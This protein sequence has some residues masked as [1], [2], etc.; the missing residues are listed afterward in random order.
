MVE[1]YASPSL[2]L[3]PEDRVVHLSERA[4]R[5]L[6]HPGGEP[7]TGAAELLRPELRMELQ[8]ALPLVRE[9]G[10][11]VRTR[12]I[13]LDLE[14][15]R[16][17]V[18]LDVRP[19]TQGDDDGFVL[20]LFDEG[21]ATVDS[22]ARAVPSSDAASNTQVEADGAAPA[23]ATESSR[24]SNELETEL[25]LARERLQTVVHGYEASRQDMHAAN[26]ELQSANEELRSTME[27]LETSKE[28]LQSMNE[29]LQTLNQ[30]NRHKV[31][32]LSQL[33]SDLQNLLSS[34]D[35]A[36]LF[37]DKQFRVLRYTPRVEQ[38]FRMRAVDR[39][40]PLSDLRHRLGY[41]GLIDDAQ[42]VLET[43]LPVEREVE[44]QDGKWYLSKILPYRTVDD[45]IEGVVL[46]FVDIT[47]RRQ[48]EEELRRA[49]IYAENIVETLHMPLL[50]LDPDLSVRSANDAFYE[51]FQAS[52]EQ[53]E[54]RLVYDL[55]NGQWSI[56]A[57]KALLEDILPDNNSFNDFEIQHTF[58][59][60]G[61]RHMLLDAR[62]L[63]HVQFIL[64]GIRDITDRKRDEEALR[65]AKAEAEHAN[66]VKSQF[67]STMSHE[68]RTPLTAV[69]GF[70]QILENEAVGPMN[71]RQK[72]HLLSITKS[73]W[74]LVRLIDEILTFARTEAGN[75][76]IR[77]EQADLGVVVNDVVN[78][79]QATASESGR[80]LKVTGADEAIIVTTDP[81]RVAQVITNLV[82]NALKYSEVGP[83]SVSIVADADG[84]NIPVSDG[85]PGIPLH[86][87]EAIFAPFFQGDSSSTRRHGGTGLGLAIARRL[88]RLLGGDVT[89]W[90][91][92][93]QGS[94]F[95]LHL[96]RECP[97]HEM[98][99]HGAE[100]P[101]ISA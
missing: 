71:E 94:T 9:H 90:S 82:G 99:L 18:V 30:E 73:A 48:A 39:G 53:T 25:R 31:E 29:E 41:D 23:A 45:R 68:L 96:P 38:L 21:P 11:P 7:T 32:E 3:N 37:L 98:A 61:H 95:T 19:A 24:R 91:E 87:Q 62:R 54:G 34:T 78:M 77:P 81:G 12:P 2:L 64:L 51:H 79:M 20:L 47:H 15:Q 100:T 33:S 26:E 70:S 67:L 88:S 56:P 27:E 22:D 85:G 49:K 89:V 43:L 46:T 44:D 28:E 75:D 52:R 97:T 69:L 74:H 92:P 1:R 35:I 57:L 14:G 101:S 4:G 55:G 86:Q 83:I 80:T 60:L 50:V 93:G 6:S 42:L 63:D 40:R 66:Q 36:T 5:Y 84:V 59:Q 65:A 17:S 76:L 72:K 13:N 16:R 10:E 58:E 8:A